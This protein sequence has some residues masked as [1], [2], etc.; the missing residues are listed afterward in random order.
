VDTRLSGRVAVVTGASQGIGRAT[1]LAFAAEGARV[2]GCARGLEALEEVMAAC[3]ELG[4]EAVGVQADVSRRDDLE[5]L[6]GRAVERFGG[7]DCLVNNAGE[8]PRGAAALTEAGWLAHVQQY[9]LSVVHACDLV[10]A[11]MRERGFGRIVTISSMA[12]ERPSSAS[13]LAATKAAV[14]NYSRGLARD[15][16]GHGITVNAVAPGLVWTPHRLSAPGGVGER[17]AA[18]TGVSVGEALAAYAE[19]AIPIGRYVQPEEVAALTVFLCSEAAG[20]ITGV[21]IPIDGGT[22]GSLLP[23]ESARASAS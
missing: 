14:N 16:A 5:R 7:V 15:L 23:P 4:G 2:V 6:V 13:A 20:A 11:G 10:M 8:A 17:L 1:A 19:Q 18:A 21:V 3:R 9:L 12:G 22:G